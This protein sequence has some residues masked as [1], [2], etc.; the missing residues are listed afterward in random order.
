MPVPRSRKTLLVT[1]EAPL[2]GNTIVAANIDSHPI[3]AT[4]NPIGVPN[5]DIISP[6]TVGATTDA[7]AMSEPL[8]VIALFIADFGT[9]EGKYAC[10]D[11]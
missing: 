6:P 9:S 4:K 1:V 3:E 10:R 2:R 11:G 5:S 8:I 7:D